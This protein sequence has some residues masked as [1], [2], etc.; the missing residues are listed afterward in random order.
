MRPQKS[1]STKQADDTV[2]GVLTMDLER[3]EESLS[4]KG[5][6]SI[7]GVDEVGRGP[8]A[9]PVVAAAVILPEE[10]DT[11]GITDS[12]ALTS[13][14][15]DYLFERLAAEGAIC[16]VG[17]MDNTAIDTL[18]ILKA[19]LMAM[20]K[21]VLDLKQ[22][23]DVVLVDGN[24]PIPNLTFPQYAIVKGDSRCVSIGAAS[25]IAKVTRD[26]I[27]EKFQALYPSFSF[28]AHKGYPTAKHL[29]EL[30][31]FGPTDIHRRSFRPVAEILEQYELF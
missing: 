7:C 12:K 16:A 6:K 15:R 17:V 24:F 25:I 10:F 5:Y 20:R 26:R 19:S 31:E 30:K 23:P 4:E 28:S 2:S 3:I 9:G 8:L 14:K 29:Q 21:A 18:N 27:M 13:R 11:E 22:S 1:V